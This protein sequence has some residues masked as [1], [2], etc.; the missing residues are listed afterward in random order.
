MWE[1]FGFYIIGGILL[2]YALDYEK[3]GL[4][5]TYANA[6]EIVG[7]YLAFV[8]FT[9]FLGGLLADRYLGYRLSVLIGGLVMAGGHFLLGTRG[10]WTFVAGLACVCIGNGFFKPNIST[11]VGN[12]Y[13]KGDPRRDAGFNIFY[14][15]INIGAF[16]AFFTAGIVRNAA[17]WGWAFWTAGFGLLFGVLILLVSWRS[18]ARADRM[19]ERSPDDVSV[20]SIFGKILAPALA[21]GLVAWWIAHS[22]FPDA[23]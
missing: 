21:V 2:L 23:K 17:G 14:M 20:G 10:E 1:R 4:G 19:P 7:T 18:L 11:M 9:P 6:N 5:L 16:L 15:G 3:G 12:L 22:N 8:Y 13:E